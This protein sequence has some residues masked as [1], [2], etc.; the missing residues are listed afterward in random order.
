MFPT[1]TAV[2]C[3]CCGQLLV[4]EVG[5]T[6]VCDAVRTYAAAAAAKA[7][8]EADAWQRALESNAAALGRI[9]AQ[10]GVPA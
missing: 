6:I 7:R 10:G 5:L 9:R 1:L 2:P 3:D 4:D 8:E